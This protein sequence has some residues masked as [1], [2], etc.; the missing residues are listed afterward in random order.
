MNFYKIFL[1]AA[2]QGHEIVTNA[3]SPEEALANARQVA[4]VECYMT[5]TAYAV[6]VEG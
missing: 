6:M 4:V 3:D 1:S 5:E 2:D